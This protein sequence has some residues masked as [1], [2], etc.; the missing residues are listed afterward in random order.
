MDQAKL[1]YCTIDRCIRKI[2]FVSKSDESDK[3]I[4]KKQLDLL[5]KKE[6]FFANLFKNKY[7]VFQMF[8][9]DVNDF[10]D[11]DDDE[12][13]EDKSKIR[14]TLI[15]K[16]MPVTTI[17]ITASNFT[18]QNSE[19]QSVPTS[20]EFYTIS[21]NLSPESIIFA[22]DQSQNLLAAYSM[23]NVINVDENAIKKEQIA[24][25]EKVEKRKV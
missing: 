3:S 15:N 4:V 22:E 11:I 9:K 18:V 20:E 2:K 16:E 5:S 24:V 19:E 13:I 6:E 21:N 14:V 12:V 17:P 1:V 25:P 8:D 7:I 23:N 10:C